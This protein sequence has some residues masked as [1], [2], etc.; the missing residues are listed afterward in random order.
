M[1]ADAGTLYIVA[2]PIGNLADL[3][4]RARDILSQSS[5]ILAEDTRNTAV[6]LKHYQI[7]TATRA[8]HEHN[9]NT[10]LESV[11]A[12]LES[13]QDIA[14]VSDAGTPLISD[15]G[16]RL[17]HAAAQRDYKLC[18]IPGASA[19]IAALSVC[20]LPTD[21]FRFEGFLPAKSAKRIERL[22]ALTTQSIT[23]VFYESS[24]RINQMLKD[25]SS[26]FPAH[27]EICVAREMTKKFESFYRGCIIDVMGMIAA[28]AN[29]QKG[30]FV[31]IIKAEAEANQ[32]ITRACELALTLAKELPLKKA[33]KIAA[34]TFAVSRNACYEFV[35]AQNN[36]RNE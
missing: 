34:Q 29:H 6:L 13:G 3:S 12:M 24:H 10:L 36:G 21:R 33:A 19:L 23:L 17:V 31:V 7:N 11:F 9:E 18:P 28:H 35:L 27:T 1:N 25:C 32:N 20:G 5:L 2:T 22:K 16:Y 30:E 8:C 4:T 15:P 14:L 26:V